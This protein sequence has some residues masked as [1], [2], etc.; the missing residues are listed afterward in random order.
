V[1]AYAGCVTVRFLPTRYMPPNKVSREINERQQKILSLLDD[2][3]HGLALREI[4]SHLVAYAT[5]RQIR[6][7]LA[8]LK[9]LN[10]IDSK[11]H[12]RGARW[13]LLNRK[14]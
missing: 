2:A 4:Y 3:G 8:F 7:D 9:T 1:N 13:I 11:G 6:E 10:L 5:E 14:S 12:G